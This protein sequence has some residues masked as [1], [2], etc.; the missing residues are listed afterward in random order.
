MRAAIPI[1]FASLALASCVG[2][3]Q[4]APPPAPQPAPPPPP[5]PAP[6]PAPTPAGDWQDRPLSSGDWFYR[7]EN[8]GSVALFGPPSSDAALSIRCELATHQ[9]RVARPGAMPTAT[10]QMRVSTTF[11]T[12]QWPASNVPAA[13]PQVVAL[14]SAQDAVL[15]QIAFSRGRFMIEAPGVAPLIVPAWAEVARVIE[16]CRG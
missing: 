5:P 6:E 11:G 8:T 10:G 3:P 12:A 14:R 13:K 4:K 1:L 15:D 2:A 16:D 7:P 9:I